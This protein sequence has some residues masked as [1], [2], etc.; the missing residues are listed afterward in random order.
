M[1]NQIPA[2][3]LLYFQQVFLLTTMD[4]KNKRPHVIPQLF[5]IPISF[6]PQMVAVAVSNDRYTNHLIRKTKEFVLNIPSA[7]MSQKVWHTAH[8]GGGADKFKRSGLTPIKAK[9]VRPPLIKECLGAVEC[10]AVGQIPAGDHTLFIA[11]VVSTTS[12]RSGR[13]MVNSSGTHGFK[14]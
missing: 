10:K 3:R 1:A 4:P 13:I 2:Y 12:F 9:A 7:D 11:K 14:L 8:P 6:K 5:T